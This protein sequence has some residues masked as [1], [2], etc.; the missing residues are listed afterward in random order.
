MK[1]SKNNSLI[2][3]DVF[4]KGEIKSSSDLHI[5]GRLEGTIEVAASLHVHKNGFV[6]GNVVANTIILSGSI[7]G[8]IKANKIILLKTGRLLGEIEYD[9][10][11][12]EEGG[13]VNGNFKNKTTISE[14]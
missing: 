2:S 3:E 7:E 6:R 1:L 11:V 9:L 10:C 8:D 4:L 13:I 12:I 14:S 5:S